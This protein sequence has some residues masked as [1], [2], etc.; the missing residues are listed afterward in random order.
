ML[1]ND[2]LN[3]YLYQFLFVTGQLVLC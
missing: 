3:D 2:A 1:V